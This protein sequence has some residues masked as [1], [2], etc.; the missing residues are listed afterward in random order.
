MAQVCYDFQGNHA[1]DVGTDC[2]AC[3]SQ[4]TSCNSCTDWIAV[5]VTTPNTDAMCASRSQG[6]CDAG[7]VGGGINPSIDTR[8][9]SQGD[10]NKSIDKVLR[11]RMQELANIKK[12]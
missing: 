12:K 10:I 2:V 1:Y 9:P 5:A 7:H 8:Q 4:T 3:C 11:R 6:V